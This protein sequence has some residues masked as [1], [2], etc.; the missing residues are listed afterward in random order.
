MIDITTIQNK[1]NTAKLYFQILVDE[2]IEDIK[3]GCSRP[4]NFYY[5]LD[6]LITAISADVNNGINTDTTQELYAQLCEILNG[7]DEIYSIDNNAIVYDIIVNNYGCV[8]DGDTIRN[9][10]LTGI[11][12]S[13]TGNLLA[14]DKI[15]EAFGKISNFI[16]NIYNTVRSTIFSGYSKASSYT[17]V[18][19][20]DTVQIA[21]GKLEKGL[22][23]NTGDQT[24]GLSGSTLSIS[25]VNGNNV[26]LTKDSVGLGNVQNVDTTNPSN[27]I[28]DSTHRFVTDTEKTTWDGKQ[29][30]LGYIP[31]D[32][33]NKGV[34]LGYTPLGADIKVPAIYL[35][36][37][38]DDVLEYPDFA[39][40]PVTG[41]SGII[42]ITIDNNKEYRW[43]GSTY[44][45]LVAS[46]GTTD[47]IVEGVVNL[48][49]TTARVLSTL[50]SGLNTSLT[51]TPSATDTILQAFGRISNF[52][53]NFVT[54]VRS[55][56]FSGYSKAITTQSVADGDTTQIAVGK[57]EKKVDDIILNTSKTQWDY[58]SFSTPS[59]FTLN[60]SKHE[61]IFLDVS[62]QN[63]YFLDKD[64]PSAD[65]TQLIKVFRFKS[66]GTGN[67]YASIHTQGGITINGS[68]TPSPTNIWLS[69]EDELWLYG[70][71]ATNFNIIAHRRQSVFAVKTV[72]TNYTVSTGDVYIKV[73]T[74]GGNVTLTLPDATYELI[75]TGKKFTIE[76]ITTDSNNVIIVPTGAQID[77]LSSYSFNFV[78]S[79]SIIKDDSNQYR[80][81]DSK[82]LHL[83]GDHTIS[84]NNTSSGTWSFLNRISAGTSINNAW[85]TLAAST[86]SFASF[87]LN[88]G[89]VYTG[90]VAGAIWGELTNYRVRILKN[91]IENDFLFAYDN[92]LFKGTNNRMAAYNQYG[93]QY[94]TDE[95]I[96]GFVYNVD[97]ISALTSATYTPTATITPATGTFY[98]GQFYYESG[99]F[100]TAI[101]DNVSFRWS[102]NEIQDA[103]TNTVLYPTKLTR[104]SSNTPTIGIGV[105]IEFEVET[106]D[107]NN[108]IGS[109]IDTVVTDNTSTLENFDILFNIM[110]NGTLSTKFKMK[111]DG[112]LEFS[113]GTD[114]TSVS[115]DPGTA[116]MGVYLGRPWVKSE[117]GEIQYLTTI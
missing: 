6:W 51:G 14:S 19:D 97:V 12:D 10:V 48:Y 49:F 29:D 24:L 33:A 100:Y 61:V 92:F 79:V 43:G 98:Q 109:S 3:N 86:S 21:V 41:T 20:G 65:Y 47:N 112:T 96:E 74:S 87:I 58:R 45:E 35:P 69:D 2:Y 110:R 104:T 57:I 53:T 90:N 80:T 26:T 46:P 116:R 44:V 114:P 55:V 31:E 85:L 115:V 56:V 71:S 30:A 113:Y 64:S 13:L 91:S 108:E 54:N 11:N 7:Y 1:V 72:S 17:P 23:G 84:G 27:I 106:S 50:L 76:K 78:G 63:G 37:Y 95:I 36:S 18:A 16:S 68:A 66:T 111:D 67:N 38:V 117:N 34:A 40:L 5:C 4:D 70:T 42:Y 52:I 88:F 81:I 22:E 99:F 94:A 28:Q 8:C 83:T 62:S 60:S 32:S 89:A 15:I 102:S 82:I 93:D 59:T 9:T 101:S 103:A 77:G 75:A 25:G 105:G 73:N 39:S 107:S